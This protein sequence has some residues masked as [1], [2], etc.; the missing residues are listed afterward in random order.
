M[1]CYVGNV[2][3][4]NLLWFVGLDQKVSSIT[5]EKNSPS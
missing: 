4:G 5:N 2:A 3:D 1:C